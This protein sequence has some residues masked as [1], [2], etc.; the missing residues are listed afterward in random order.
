MP[1]PPPERLQVPRR[2]VDQTV[3]FMQNQGRQLCEGVVL[4][5]VESKAPRRVV[6]AIIPDQ[7][8]VPANQ[9]ACVVLPLPFRE[10]L[11]REMYARGMQVVAQVHSHPGDAFHSETDD[12]YPVIHHRGAISIVVPH[13]A[14]Y[15]LNLA[16]AAVFVLE[17]WPHWKEL[18]LQAKA[19]L[20]ELGA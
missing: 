7:E 18:D 2:I 1:P 6:E 4:W 17:A 5:A 16:N 14:R 9:G 19:A 15:G 13:F 12:R 10:R 20:L 8:P 11:T 3:R